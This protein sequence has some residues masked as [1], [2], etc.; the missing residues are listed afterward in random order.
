[1]ELA[2]QDIASTDIGSRIIKVNHAGEHGAVSIYSGQILLARLTAP[3]MVSGLV[4]F[5]S[6][7]QRHRAL[8]WA[9]LQRRGRPRC[10]SY[11]LCGVGGYVL[12]LITGLLG[13]GA[14][15][16]TTMAVERD[17]LR[18]LEHQLS[19]LRGS[20]PFAVAAISA[21]VAEERE[22]HDRSAAQVEGRQFWSKILTP[23]VS[24]STEAVIWIG[25][26][27]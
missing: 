27:S 7:E 26:R 8:F 4:E 6:H 21:I 15:A 12:G 13:S 3:S 20:D 10:R 5:R 1:M 19:V 25:M 24:V 23:I 9:E 22:H 11:F 17:V 14:I 16:A 2:A 18:H